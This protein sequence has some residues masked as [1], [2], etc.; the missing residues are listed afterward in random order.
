MTTSQT[1]CLVDSNI[2]VYAIDPAEA[3][4]QRLAQSL[5]QALR[6]SGRGVLSVQV[7]GEFFR[8]ATR[9]IALPLTPAQAERNL[10][11][12]AA[13]FPVLETTAVAILEAARGVQAYPLS[14]WDG[15]IWATAKLNGLPYLLSED[16][17]DGQVIEGVRIMNPFASTFDLS[18]L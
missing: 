7:L 1:V 16:M 8:A 4:K 6:A 17:G 3:A 9:R 15:V 10:T 14:F 18:V 12:F 11:S 13:A 5:L 2:L